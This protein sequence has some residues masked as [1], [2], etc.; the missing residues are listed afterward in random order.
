MAASYI[1]TNQQCNEY[2]LARS[3]SQSCSQANLDVLGPPQWSLWFLAGF[4]ALMYFFGGK[5]QQGGPYAILPC[6]K[7]WLDGMLPQ[8]HNH[9]RIKPTPREWAIVGQS[10]ANKIERR[11]IYTENAPCPKRAS[12]SAPSEGQQERREGNAK[13]HRPTAGDTRTEC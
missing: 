5:A 4:L 7:L 11:T 6:T 1:V 8:K 13:S 12:A 10:A 9:S 2:L 3:C